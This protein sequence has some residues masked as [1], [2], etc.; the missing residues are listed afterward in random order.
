MSLVPASPVIYWLSKEELEEVSPELKPLTIPF[1]R[2]DELLDEYGYGFPA[3]VYPAMW[4]YENEWRMIGEFR[5]P[6]KETEVGVSNERQKREP[7]RLFGCLVKRIF[8]D[9]DYVRIYV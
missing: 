2:V 4:S 1:E 3:Y 8:I 5:I 7:E 6:W 9:P